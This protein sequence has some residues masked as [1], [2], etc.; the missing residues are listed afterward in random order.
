MCYQPIT[1]IT[2]N[3]ANS[4]Q[5]S[6]LLLLSLS[7]E[8]ALRDAAA[9]PDAELWQRDLTSSAQTSDGATS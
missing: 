1:L 8:T 7:S 9:S 3:L 2:L 6:L 4:T 5:P